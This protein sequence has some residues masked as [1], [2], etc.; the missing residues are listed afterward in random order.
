MWKAPYRPSGEI[1]Q[2]YTDGMVTV[3][4]VRDAAEP[5]RLPWEELEEKLRLPFA[6]RRVGVTRYYA[7]RQNQIRVEK[8][9]RVQKVAG[10]T[11]Q[12]VAVLHD[13]SK[14]RI[15]QVQDVPGVFPPS[16]DLT[17]TAYT[18]GVGEN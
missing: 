10:I 5:G 3:C 14:Y 11:S 12:D 2:S 4:A 9:L 16:L 13:G 1:S 7:A 8:V 6:E 17:L 15:D 18:Q